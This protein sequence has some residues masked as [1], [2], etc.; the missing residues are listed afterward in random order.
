MPPEDRRARLRRWARELKTKLRTLYLASRHPRTPWYARA[1][2][3]VVV[4]YALSPIDLI[5]DPIPVLGYLDDL[6]LLPL[7][8]WLTWRLIPADVWAECETAAQGQEGGDLPRSRAAAGA[9]VL[10]W[11]VA[12]ALAGRFLW[13]VLR[14][15]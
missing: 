10:L 4:G 8:V 1:L 9:I 15:R 11:L 14:P 12:L 13:P 7:G 3:V 2:A 6:I 5:P